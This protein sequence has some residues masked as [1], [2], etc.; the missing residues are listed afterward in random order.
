MGIT[1]WPSRRLD[2]LFLV[3]V[4]LL[5]GCKP[6]TTPDP[7]AFAARS[8]VSP[9][10]PIGSEAVT[11]TGINIPAKLSRLLFH[12]ESQRRTGAACQQHRDPASRRPARREC[13]FR[14]A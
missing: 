4:L 6:D 10:T 7:F 14:T 12:P 3:A 11:I 2:A 1:K 9:D 13:G 5:Q 8:K